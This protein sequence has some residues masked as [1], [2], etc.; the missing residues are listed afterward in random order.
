MIRLFTSEDY[1]EA[2]TLWKS[3][4]GVG[5]RESDDSKEVIERFLHR[6]PSTNF[7]AVENGKIVG[8]ILTGHDGR[9]GYLYHTCVE[10]MHRHK[11]IGREL[12]KYA[13]TAMKAEGIA[14]IS[15]FCLRHNNQGNQFWSS[16]G[17]TLREDL[18]IYN[19]VIDEANG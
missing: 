18:N 4:P 12:V 2:Y 10:E 11:S 6:N 3:T 8:T 7:V 14:R 15:L 5:V 13:I 19:V 1:E 17:W 9:R 16:M